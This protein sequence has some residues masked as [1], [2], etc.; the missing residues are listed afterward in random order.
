VNPELLSHSD[1][2]HF[3]PRSAPARL[4]LSYSGY[5]GPIHVVTPA[6][7]LFNSLSWN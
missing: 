1:S 7:P 6:I 5:I 2:L 3:V 4:L